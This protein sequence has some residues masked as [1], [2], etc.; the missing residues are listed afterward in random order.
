MKPNYL[1]EVNQLVIGIG[2]LVLLI[3]GAA[4]GVV[5]QEVIAYFK[6]RRK[7]NDIHKK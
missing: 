4:V 6:E 5:A 7:A 2:W 3:V 1:I